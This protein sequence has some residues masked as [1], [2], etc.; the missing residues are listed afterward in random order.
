MKKWF[1]LFPLLLLAPLV[2]PARGGELEVP[3]AADVVVNLEFVQQVLA[4]G[5]RCAALSDQA[6]MLAIGHRPGKDVPHVSLF[7]LDAEGTAADKAIPL[8]LPR[9]E[10][11]KERA[12]FPVSL[13][14][15]P[16][17]PLLYVWQDIE[18]AKMATGE[19]P[20]VKELDHLLIYNIEGQVPELLLALARGPEFALGQT[21]GSLAL[22]RAGR[23]LFLPNVCT[24]A[25][26]AAAITPAVGV[27][28]LDF[29][30]LPLLGEKGPAEEKLPADPRKATALRDTR[31]G[32]C[33]TALQAG[34]LPGKMLV[35]DAA[36][37]LSGF[38]T[39]LGFVP[40]SDDVVIMGGTYGPVVW[41]EGNRRARFNHFFLHA[42]YGAPYVDRLSAHPTL[43]VV[44]FSVLRT[45][46]I[47]RMEHADGYLTLVPQQATLADTT[48]QSAPVVL[49]KRHL[50]AVGGVNRVGLPRIDAT[51]AFKA[52]A[53]TD[54]SVHNPA[55]E[56]LAYSEKFDRLYVA[57]EKLP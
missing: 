1:R 23:R 10:V 2:F 44:Y 5:S 46:W 57:V 53:R 50:V 54:L 39:G 24:K 35:S 9:S 43:P 42:N 3:E 51:G 38:P 25:P 16:Q 6:H 52:E 18:P 47:Y 34:K 14:F 7:R 21:A 49:T 37:P 27:L 40:V 48:M 41:D 55:V 4:P 19:D 33:K 29:L 31:V 17:L 22:D 11:L 26:G 13:A 12:N 56:A 32:E 30:G 45:H 28:P 15:H 36:S 8:K 20:A